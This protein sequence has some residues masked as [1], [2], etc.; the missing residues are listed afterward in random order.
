MSTATT[1]FD[2]L[3]LFCIYKLEQF[4]AESFAVKLFPSFHDLNSLWPWAGVYPQDL[5][6]IRYEIG[7]L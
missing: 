6:D 4:L 7:H 5:S 2:M 3:H 1:E